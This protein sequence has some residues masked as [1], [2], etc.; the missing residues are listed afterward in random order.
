M[1]LPWTFVICLQEGNRFLV[2]KTYNL[3][4]NS[5]KIIIIYK[6]K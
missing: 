4:K 6:K 1:L 5:C 2:R 3:S